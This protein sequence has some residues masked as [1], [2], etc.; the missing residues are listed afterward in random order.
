MPQRL[1]LSE[2]LHAVAGWIKGPAW[3]WPVGLAAVAIIVSIIAIPL[4]A[5]ARFADPAKGLDDPL[6]RNGLVKIAIPAGAVLGTAAGALVARWY[7]RGGH[8]PT[9]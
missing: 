3:H 4:F 2:R 7:R 6:I 8:L 1:P 9:E 5:L